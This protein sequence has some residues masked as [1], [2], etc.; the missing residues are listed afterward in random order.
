MAL[1][2]AASDALLVPQGLKRLAEIIDSAKE[3]EYTHRWGSFLATL[4]V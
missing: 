2:G 3:F 1:F 4:Q